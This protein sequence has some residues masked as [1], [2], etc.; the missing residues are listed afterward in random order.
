M[1]PQGFS[2]FS[3]EKISTTNDYELSKLST[4]RGLIKVHGDLAKD[5][6][7]T[8]YGFDN[9]KSRRYV[10]S[11]EDYATYEQRHQAFSYQMRTGLLT[12]VFCLIGF[13]GNDPNFLGWLEW[14]KD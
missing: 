2:F 14:M 6:L 11:E 5:S 8:N 9:D 10:I 3:A 12:G 1:E 4:K 13:S 7:D